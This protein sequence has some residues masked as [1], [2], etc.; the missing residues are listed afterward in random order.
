MAYAEVGDVTDRLASDEPTPEILALITVRLEDVERMIRKRIPD[1]A[2]KVADQDFL[3]DVKQVEADAVLRMARNP[4]GYLSEGD[5]NYQ[6]MLHRDMASGKLEI[7]DDEWRT[8]GVTVSGF[9]I[10]VPRPVMPT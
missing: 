9:A 5:G 4:E 7:T 6:Y 1:L 10:I 2:T 8:L 3:A